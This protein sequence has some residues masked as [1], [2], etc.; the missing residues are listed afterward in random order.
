MQHIVF[1]E[2]RDGGLGGEGERMRKRRRRR[3]RG[4]EEWGGG[5][6]RESEIQ[7]EVKRPL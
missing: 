4:G 3:R 2:T 1:V 7:A 6:E 5:E